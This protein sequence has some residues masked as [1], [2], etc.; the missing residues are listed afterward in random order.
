MTSYHLIK[1]QDGDIYGVIGAVQYES[2]FSTEMPWQM[3]LFDRPPIKLSDSGVFANLQQIFIAQGEGPR[4]TT[5]PNSSGKSFEDYLTEGMKDF[6]LKHHKITL[7][8]ES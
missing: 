4:W 5:F 7:R 2:S 6:L 3:V 1:V 8:L